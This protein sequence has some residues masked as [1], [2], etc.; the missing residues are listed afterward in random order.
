MNSGGIAKELFGREPDIP[1]SSL[2]AEVG[3]SASARTPYSYRDETVPD[4]DPARGSV[5]TSMEPGKGDVPSPSPHELRWCRR[6]WPD[7]GSANSLSVE[8]GGISLSKPGW[9][10]WRRWA[11]IGSHSGSSPDDRA[12]VERETLYRGST[13]D[14]EPRGMSALSAEANDGVFVTELA[15]CL[16]VELAGTYLILEPWECCSVGGETG[17]TRISPTIS[18]RASLKLKMTTAFFLD[19]HWAAELRAARSTPT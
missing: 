1:V 11:G 6:S 14:V 3:P 19:G 10:A 18:V 9:S 13:A 5:T 8:G 4:V 12:E 7:G 2:L 15:S 16:D 17:E